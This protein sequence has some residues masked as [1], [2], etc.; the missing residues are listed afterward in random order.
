[1]SEQVNAISRRSFLYGSALTAAIVL[2]A[3]PMEAFAVTSAE[4]RAE[5]NATLSRLRD[6][7]AKLENATE[8]YYGALDA[9]QAAKDRMDESQA[10]IDEASVKIGD[11]QDQLGTRAK[12]MYR[13]GSLSF[14]DILMGANSFQAFSTN[15][16]ILNKMNDEDAA[17]VEETKEL[18]VEVQKEKE[19]YAKQE[20]IAAEEAHHA[21][22]VTDQSQALVTELQSA[23]Q[24]LNAEAQELLR[25]EEEAAARRAA[26]EAAARE[27]E[28]RRREN[29]NNGNNGDNSNKKNSGGKIPAFVGGS[30][31][32]RARNSIGCFSYSWG[33][34]GPSAYD[35]SGFVSYCLTGR[36]G[37]RVG[38]TGTFLGWPEVPV[39]QAQP[40]DICVNG[41]H[42]GIYAG[43]GQMIHCSSTHNQVVQASIHAGMIIVRRP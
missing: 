23:Y 5:A 16:D 38:T 35:C 42:C 37:V 36:S 10:R 18:R 22:E 3:G 11:L 33:G 26:E 12:S 31:I 8:E 6:M 2:Q 29:A 9:Q 15:W 1:M 27:A 14:L 28:Q 32:E 4:K 39:S 25:Q 17:L 41:K 40:G 43:G 34:L 13:N 19:E 30:V 7:E 21:K 24:N 20:A